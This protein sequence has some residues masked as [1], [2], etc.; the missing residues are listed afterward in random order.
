MSTRRPAP[1]IWCST[2]RCSREDGHL[3]ACCP[4]VKKKKDQAR[5][6]KGLHRRRG[7]GHLNRHVHILARRKHDGKGIG[8]RS[9]WGCRGWRRSAD[10][11]HPR[12]SR[13]TDD[14]SEFVAKCC[15]NPAKLMGLFPQKGVDRRRQRRR[16]RHHRPRPRRSRSTARRWK[17]TPT[18][19]RTRAGRC[20][21]FAE[22]T[23][24]RG[25]K[26]VDDY[27]FVGE[28]GWGRWL[29]RERAGSLDAL[30]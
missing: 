23:F 10:R 30:N 19:A 21:G 12:R 18:G 13:R 14:R 8:P 5:L 22:T 6:W 3:F 26:I 16:H 29:P 1:S 15:T 9:R 27:K 24:S 17:R 2:I 4:Q 25:R 28:S 20:A 7:L 11:L